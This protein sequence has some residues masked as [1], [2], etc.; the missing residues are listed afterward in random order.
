[1]ASTTE[2]SDPLSPESHVELVV[3][4]PCRCGHQKD[5]H[6]HYRRGTDCAACS[7]A[8]FHGR[9]VVTLSFGRVVPS[10][11]VPDE[12]P[13]PSGPY[14][15]PTHVVGIPSTRQGQVALPPIPRVPAEPVRVEAPLRG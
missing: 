9:L 10:V 3:R 11:I 7:C 4:R 13:E 15:R 8:A 1:V 12:V 14:L 5:A 2:V 6:E